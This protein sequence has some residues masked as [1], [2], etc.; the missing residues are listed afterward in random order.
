MDGRAGVTGREDG[1]CAPG[2]TVVEGGGTAA[3]GAAALVGDGVPGSG[4]KARPAVTLTPGGN[5]VAG[6]DSPPE[7]AT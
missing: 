1:S 6:A 2:I 5:G 4:T 3:G 7:R